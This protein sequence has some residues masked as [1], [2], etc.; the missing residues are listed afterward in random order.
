MHLWLAYTKSIFCNFPHI[1]ADVRK[2]F[3][4]KVTFKT[5]FIGKSRY[6]KISGS[7]NW[8]NPLHEKCLPRKK[9]LQWLFIFFINFYADHSKRFW[10]KVC[11]NVIFNQNTGKSTSVVSLRSLSPFQVEL[12]PKKTTVLFLN[13]YWDQ[14]SGVRDQKLQRQ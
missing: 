4:G 8:I 2:N 7:F 10:L 5:D 6:D 1:S 14:K 9:F 11:K 12:L 3:S 13:L